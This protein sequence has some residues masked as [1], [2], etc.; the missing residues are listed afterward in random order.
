MAVFYTW[1]KYAL[2]TSY[3]LSVHTALFKKMYQALFTV[4][5]YIYIYINVRGI[6][7]IM[8]LYI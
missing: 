2:P 4:I 3:T 7:I 5:I 8:Y 6:Y 1:V